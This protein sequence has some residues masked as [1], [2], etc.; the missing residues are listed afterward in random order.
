MV[1][2]AL[3][4]EEALGSGAGGRVIA[5]KGQIQSKKRPSQPFS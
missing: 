4:L 2:T 1:F 5:Q 3:E